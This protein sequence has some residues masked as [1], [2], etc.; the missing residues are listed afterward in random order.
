MSSKLKG[1]SIE[2]DK[3]CLTAAS[4]LLVFPDLYGICCKGC[5]LLIDGLILAYRCRFYDWDWA[6]FKKFCSKNRKYLFIFIGFI[7][8][9]IA[10][11]VFCIYLK[12][13]ALLI[14]LL[15]L[16]L[17]FGIFVDRF[18]VKRYQQFVSGKQAHLSEIILFL[19]T[20][21]PDHDLYSKSQVEEIIQRLTKRIEV[22]IPF[23]KFKS[24]LSSFGKAIVLPA[25]TF[26]AGVYSSTISQMEIPVVISWVVSIILILGILSLA[27]N[28]LSQALQK[29]TCRDYDAAMAFREDLL[30]IQLL[31]LCTNFN[32]NQ[33]VE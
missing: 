27:W 22:K 19:Q 15:I 29:I 24:S 3:Y 17:F 13:S 30:D 21:V 8:V 14:I 28:I 33:A 18:T 26:V 11:V 31:F 20:A 12:F 9:V 16:E 1:R 4:S 7:L 32:A 6:S 2:I 23:K 10:S 25:I 5:E